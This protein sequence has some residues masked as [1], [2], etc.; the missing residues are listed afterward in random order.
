VQERPLLSH[1]RTNPV[2][3]LLSSIPFGI[4]LIVLILAYASVLSALPQVRGA[5]ELSEM[6]A[7]EHWLFTSLVLLLCA[8]VTI[9]TL[10]RIRLAWINAGVLTV[11]AGLLILC[12][13]AAWYFGT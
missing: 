8:S 7:F 1:W 12:G 9:A 3:R 13:G 6:A 2:V 11:H 4:T 5:L 10:T